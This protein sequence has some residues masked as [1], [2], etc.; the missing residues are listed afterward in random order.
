MY[1]Q[2]PSD[3]SMRRRRD[4]GMFVCR[5]SIPEPVWLHLWRVFECAHCGKAIIW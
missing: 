5:C 2:L 1:T 3:R 4:L